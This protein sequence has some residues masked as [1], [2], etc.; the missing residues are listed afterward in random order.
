[1]RSGHGTATAVE[2]QNLASL[3]LC[4]FMNNVFTA[5][6]T[7]FLQLQAFRVLFFVLGAAVIDAIAC[8]ALKMNCLA[9]DGSNVWCAPRSSLKGFCV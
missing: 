4:F 9:H 7:K 1:M 5:K 8:G 2:T 3:L 6:T